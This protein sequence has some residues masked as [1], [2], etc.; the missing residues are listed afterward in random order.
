MRNQ[1]NLM[2]RGLAVLG[3]A[4]LLSTAWAADELN[5][6]ARVMQ[7][8]TAYNSGN[9]S[10]IAAMYAEDG[11]R[12]PPNEETVSGRA[13][14]L[15]QLEAG[16]AAGRQQVKLGLTHSESNG[17]LGFATGTYAIMGADGAQLDQGKWMNVSRRGADNAWLIHCDIFNS[18]QPLPAK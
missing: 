13:A 2:Y 5:M 7:W 9:L 18:N 8:E 10:A 17:D 4:L 12:M 1:Y 15:A 3:L 14:I 11:C 6:E 16:K